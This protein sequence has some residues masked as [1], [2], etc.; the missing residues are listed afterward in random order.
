MKKIWNIW[1]KFSQKY[2]KKQYEIYEINLKITDLSK[3]IED[4]LL[5]NKNNSKLIKLKSK[6][7]DDFNQINIDKEKF[8]IM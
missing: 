3:L 4:V 1:W 8:I 7:I 6:K 5:F 2:V